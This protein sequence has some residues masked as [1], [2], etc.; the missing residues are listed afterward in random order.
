MK[1]KLKGITMIVI[2]L[3]GILGLVGCSQKA[4][5]YTEEEHIQRVTERIQKKYIDTDLSWVDR[6]Q[7]TSFDVFPLYNI[8]N[9]LEYFLVEFEPYGFL[10]IQLRDERKKVFSWTG[11]STSMYKISATGNDEWISNDGKIVYNKSPY[12]I[13]GIKNERRYLLL[14]YIVAVK[15]KEK[16]VNLIS[17]EE[18]EISNGEVT[19][20]QVGIGLDFGWPKKDN[21]L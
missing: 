5:K 11:A 2:M 12:F 6:E 14:G 9:K 8:N 13:A 1:K 10:F 7:P 15:K 4:S 16:F 18:V 20:E 19:K 17:L 3:F 21:D